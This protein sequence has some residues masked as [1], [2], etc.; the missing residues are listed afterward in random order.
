MDLGT[1]DRELRL[2]IEVAKNIPA[3]TKAR[4]QLNEITV[5]TRWRFSGG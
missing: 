5:Y 1:Q 4:V 3:V 2:A